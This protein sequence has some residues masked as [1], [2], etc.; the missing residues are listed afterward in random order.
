MSSPPGPPALTGVHKIVSASM[1]A[2]SSLTKASFNF[3]IAPQAVLVKR[4]RLTKC[5]FAF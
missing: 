1:A 5:K 2:A 4:C 3:Y